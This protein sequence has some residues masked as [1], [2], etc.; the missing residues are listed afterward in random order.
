[1]AVYTYGANNISFGT[2]NTWANN[3]A[4]Q[5][6]TS[7]SGS[8]SD[9]YPAQAAPFQVSEI[10]PNTAIFYGNVSAD[11]GGTVSMS[12]PYT[13][14][15]TTSFTISNLLIDTYSITIAAA[16]TYPYAFH[17]WRDATGGGGTQLSTNATLTLT[18]T[19]HT[20]VTTFYAYFTTSHIDPPF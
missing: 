18:D 15:S 16:A 6:N 14:A 17:S 12:S 10:G 5:A 9:F 13:V 7:L 8:L 2:F 3:V 20:S 11:N 19:D 4:A 1:M